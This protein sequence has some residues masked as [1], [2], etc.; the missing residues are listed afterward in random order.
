MGGI[1]IE[2]QV[3]AAAAADTAIA[4]KLSEVCPVAIFA[5]KDDGTLIIQDENLDECTLCDLCL[6]VAPKGAV[7]VIKLYAKE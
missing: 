1:F 3:D 5:T 7:Q 6:E 2:V 4:K